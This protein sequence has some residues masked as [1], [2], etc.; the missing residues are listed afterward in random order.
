M[1]IW[2]MRVACW[3]PKAT[4]IHSEYVTIIAFPL[5]QYLPELASMLRCRYSLVTMSVW[6]LVTLNHKPICNL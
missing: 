2:R 1:A 4:D 5:L 3:I 6:Q